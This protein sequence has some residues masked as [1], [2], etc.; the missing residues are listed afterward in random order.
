MEYFE[1]EWHSE[2]FTYTAATIVKIVNNSSNVTRTSI[3][4][5]ERFSLP[6][7]VNYAAQIVSGSIITTTMGDT[8][9]VL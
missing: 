3:V 8:E 1:F 9:Y 6:S 5:A 4:Q 7:S 2:E